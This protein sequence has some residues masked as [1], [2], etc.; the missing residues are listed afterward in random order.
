[1]LA[2]HITDIDTLLSALNTADG[3]TQ[4]DTS[5]LTVKDGIP[6]LYIWVGEIT[7]ADRNSSMKSC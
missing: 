3:W 7:M 4:W 2:T 5:F 6:H 1:M